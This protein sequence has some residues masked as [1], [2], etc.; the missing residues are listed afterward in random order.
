MTRQRPTKGNTVKLGECSNLL[1]NNLLDRIT[2]TA[3][4]KPLSEGVMEKASKLNI[5]H[6]LPEDFFPIAYFC[7]L[8]LFCHFMSLS[9]FLTY[10]CI[11]YKVM[12]DH[13]CA[14]TV[15]SATSSYNCNIAITAEEQSLL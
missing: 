15:S 6:V 12:V 1:D 9:L 5:Q 11:N 14:Y 2:L 10:I 8:S 13:L 7:S 3:D 4:Q